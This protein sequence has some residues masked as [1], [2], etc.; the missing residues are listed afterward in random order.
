VDVLAHVAVRA[1]RER[2]LRTEVV[3]LRSVLERGTSA[4]SLVA[5]SP[6]MRQALDLAARAARSKAPVL[7]T[8]ESGTGKSRLARFIHDSGDRAAKPFVQINCAALPAALLEAE[9]F[10]VRRGAF[11]GADTLCR[12]GAGDLAGPGTRGAFELCHA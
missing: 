11:T 1:L 8:G 12:T 10:G 2:A 3:R 5:K 6:A 4:E 9:L 7:L